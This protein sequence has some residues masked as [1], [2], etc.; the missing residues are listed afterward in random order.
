VRSLPLLALFISAPAICAQSD[1]WAATVYAGVISGEPTWQDVIKDPFG[2]NYADSYLIAGALSRSY[3]HFRNEGLR[4]EA[5]A[6]LVYNFGDQHHLEINAVPVVARWRRFPWDE[7]L[8]TS[9]AFGLGLSYATEVPELEVE[10]EGSSRKWL[11]YWVLELTA[12]PRA[13]PWAIT[14]RLHHRSVA[15]GLMGEDGGVNA[16]G[17]G[18]RYRFPA[19]TG[20]RP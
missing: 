19:S 17:L 15:W 6:Q 8:A 11:I 14:M 18:L 1:E 2:A 20:R 16:V 3:A 4:L 7:R 10:Q 5:E 13:A 12:G 9:A